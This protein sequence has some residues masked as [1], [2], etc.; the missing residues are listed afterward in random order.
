MAI[1]AETCHARALA[2]LD[3][4]CPQDE[5]GLSD[6]VFIE[7]SLGGEGYDFGLFLRTHH[8]VLALTEVLGCGG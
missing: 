8:S 1:G 5:G 3:H 4:V 6:T 7:A 2:H